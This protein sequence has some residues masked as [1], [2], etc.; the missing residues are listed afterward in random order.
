MPIKS[1]VICNLALYLI[2][3]KLRFKLGTY[4]GEKQLLICA[5]LHQQYVPISNFQTFHFS[6]E[7]IKLISL[8]LILLNSIFFLGKQSMHLCLTWFLSRNSSNIVAEIFELKVIYEICYGLR[9]D[10]ICVQKIRAT[11]FNWLEN[12]IWNRSGNGH[13]LTDHSVDLKQTWSF[14]PRVSRFFE[15]CIFFFIFS[16]FWNPRFSKSTDFANLS[17]SKVFQAKDQFVKIIP[18]LVYSSKI[19]PRMYLYVVSGYGE[20]WYTLLVFR[21]NNEKTL[22]DQRPK[23]QPDNFC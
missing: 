1:S 19:P 17:S 21:L 4:S 13:V 23:P 9:W 8:K 20:D 15:I 10:S 22:F 18:Y 12:M 3:Y 7:S 11:A 6:R 5:H 16:F 2:D 14:I